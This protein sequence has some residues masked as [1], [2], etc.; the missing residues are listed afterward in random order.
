[1]ASQSEEVEGISALSGDR[2]LSVTV[3]RVLHLLAAS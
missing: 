1:M 2:L 3:P